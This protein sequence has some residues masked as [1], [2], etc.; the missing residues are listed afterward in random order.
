MLQVAQSHMLQAL[1][2]QSKVGCCCTQTCS[3]FNQDEQEGFT[4]N[5]LTPALAK[6][7][8]ARAGNSLCRKIFLPL[9]SALVQ[10]LLHST[11]RTHHVHS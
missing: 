5:S 11:K 10:V 9:V 7:T 8:D 2:P 1:Y 6:H 3:D 4:N